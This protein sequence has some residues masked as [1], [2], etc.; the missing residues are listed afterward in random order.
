M[1]DEQ[2]NQIVSYLTTHYEYLPD[3]SVKH[4]GEGH[5]AYKGRIFSNG[6]LY[7]TFRIKGKRWTCGKHTVV[8]ILCRG[9]YPQ[10]E[11]DHLDNNKQNN[12]IEN[13]RECSRAENELN[14]SLRWIENKVTHV[15][16]VYFEKNRKKTFKTR[17]RGRLLKFTDPYEAFNHVTLCGKTYA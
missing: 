11:L 9:K 1:T 3:G 4:K 12:K 5:R 10:S 7:L 14:K 15:P 16:G 13:L 6:Y 2:R 8:W 17:F